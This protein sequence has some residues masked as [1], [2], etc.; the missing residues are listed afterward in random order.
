VPYGTAM[1]RI[2]ELIEE[3]LLLKRPRSKSGRSFSLHP[4]RK[5]IREFESYA[6]LLKAHVGNAF[7]FTQSGSEIEDFFFGASYMAAKILSFPSAMHTAV[8][9]DRMVRFFAPSIRRSRHCPIR[10]AP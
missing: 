5:L 2:G 8:G 6:L 1:R 4:T 9:Y 7:G 3:E 10:F